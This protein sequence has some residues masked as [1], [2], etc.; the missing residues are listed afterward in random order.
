MTQ[1]IKTLVVDDEP[2]ARKGIEALL[3]RDA[4]IELIGSCANGNDAIRIIGEKTPDLM[5]LDVQ[6]PGMD[7]FQ[8][9]TKLD[10]GQMPV[11]V[12]IT[13]YDQYALRAFQVHALDY[14]LK[15]YSDEQFERALVNAKQYIRDKRRSRI[16]EGILA[17]IRNNDKVTENMESAVRDIK[18][19]GYLDRVVVKERGRIFFVDVEKI[20][21]IES[22]DYYVCLH[23]SGESY[24]IR[25]TMTELEKRLDP[26]RF[27]RTH[28]ST[29]VNI[30][31]IKE[32]QRYNH[33]DYLIV[34]KNGER[35]KLSRTYRLRMEATLGHRL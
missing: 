2:L 1:S 34:L 16:T 10:P 19:K 29:I 9:L 35:L 23:V 11:V 24:L 22:A 18:D 6:M 25:E 15:S 26:S 5:F 33:G 13:A 4:E 20:D 14:L 3:R 31:R 27:Q 7:G 21:W 28:R 30:D 32:L 17:L 8:M 12:F